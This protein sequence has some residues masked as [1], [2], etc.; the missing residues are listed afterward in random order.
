MLSLTS[1]VP[2]VTESADNVPAK[3]VIAEPTPTSI[4]WSLESLVS[5]PNE[6]VVFT[7][8]GFLILEI[9]KDTGVSERTAVPNVTIKASPLLATVAPELPERSFVPTEVKS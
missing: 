7:Y 8:A 6:S 5:M 4:K 1:V 2:G 9:T 3:V